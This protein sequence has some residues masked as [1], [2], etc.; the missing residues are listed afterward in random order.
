VNITVTIGFSMASCDGELVGA[1]IDRG[2]F[3]LGTRSAGKH[4]VV[5]P[6]PQPMSATRPRCGMPIPVMIRVASGP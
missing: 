4:R 5:L 3:A 1:R 2:D 6:V